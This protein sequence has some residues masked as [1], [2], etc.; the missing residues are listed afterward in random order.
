[1]FFEPSLG[2][3]FFHF[4][5]LK[6]KAHIEPFACKTK[7]MDTTITKRKRI[8][9]LLEELGSTVRLDSANAMAKAIHFSYINFKFFSSFSLRPH[10][11]YHTVSGKMIHKTEGIFVSRE[12]GIRKH[13]CIDRHGVAHEGSA[14]RRTTY[15][16]NWLTTNLGHRA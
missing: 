5:W 4:N 16:R 1:M 10:K 11:E 15:I 12:S 9:F 2:E 7:L 3:F 13:L 14:V 6:K 8:A